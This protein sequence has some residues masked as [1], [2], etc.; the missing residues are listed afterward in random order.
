MAQGGLVSSVPFC[1]YAN[2]IPT[3]SRHVSL[4][5]DADVTALA[6]TSRSPSLFAGYLEAYLGRLDLWLRDWRIAVNVSKSNA[7][8]FLKT[9]RRVQKP[10]PMQ[11][12]G[13]PI[14]WVETASYLGV[15]LDTWLTWWAHVN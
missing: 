8:F 14:V 5:Q 11:L 10:T 13:E 9:T 12:L 1:L 3:P 15:M 7:V 4:A 6:A 2:D